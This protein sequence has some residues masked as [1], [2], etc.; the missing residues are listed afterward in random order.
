MAIPKSRLSISPLII[1]H[2]KILTNI[3]QKGEESWCHADN[4]IVI[5]HGT[6]TVVG[7]HDDVV[8]STPLF[9]NVI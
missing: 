4:I 5:R 8:I 9:S 3:S 6:S 1:L 7:T 2:I